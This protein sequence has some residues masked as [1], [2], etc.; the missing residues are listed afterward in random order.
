MKNL[1]L[2]FATA[3]VAVTISSCTCTDCDYGE[4]DKGK[5]ELWRDAAIGSYTG[6][7]SCNTAAA[8]TIVVT[9]GSTDNRI[10]FDNGFYAQMQTANSF[11]IP[12]QTYFDVEEQANMQVSGSGTYKNGTLAFTATFKLNGQSLSCTFSGN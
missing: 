4:C 2:L 7:V 3:L 9:A 5:C 12:Q 10:E 8:S 11:N 6:N 1:K